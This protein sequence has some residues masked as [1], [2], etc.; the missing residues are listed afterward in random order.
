[1][2]STAVG[3]DPEWEDDDG[4]LYDDEFVEEN[5]EEE[6]EDRLERQ[7]QAQVRP[8]HATGLFTGKTHVA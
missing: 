7:A 4:G 3:E 8:L 5:T 1:M 2:Q 6:P